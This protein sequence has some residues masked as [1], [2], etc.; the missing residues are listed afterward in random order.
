MI[1]NGKQLYC[2]PQ[3]LNH[4]NGKVRKQDS[5]CYGRRQRHR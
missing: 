1:V 4:L 3:L 5:D 2:T